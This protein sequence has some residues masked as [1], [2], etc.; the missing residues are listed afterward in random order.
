ML[1]RNKQSFL[2]ELNFL[3][4]LRPIKI[5]YITIQRIKKEN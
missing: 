1:G 3:V 2:V 5:Q 4:M